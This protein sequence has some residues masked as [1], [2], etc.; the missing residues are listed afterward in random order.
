MSA[1]I[2]SSR[3]S[4]GLRFDVGVA[5]LIS[6]G[7]L[8]FIS[9]GLAVWAVFAAAAHEAAHLLAIYACGLRLRRVS[10]HAGGVRMELNA[11]PP[12]T[13]AALI[14]AAGC[15]G[16]LLAAG[17]VKAFGGA[18]L[19]AYI[20]FGANLILCALNALPHSALDGGK[21]LRL[22][23]GERPNAERISFVCDVAV[24][25]LLTAAGAY[26]F[27]TFGKNPTA[28]LLGLCLVS[29]LLTFRKNTY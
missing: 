21:L 18:S 15:F 5:F 6:I 2:T 22:A 19:R 28:L 16:N 14:L 25:F 4:Q 12:K 27:F 10:L 24:T 7:V 20:F 23:L 3:R 13:K 11:E 8:A 1:N 9:G 29:K 17:A 26:I